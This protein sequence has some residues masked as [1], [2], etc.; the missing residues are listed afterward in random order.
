MTHAPKIAAQKKQPVSILRN[1]K[2]TLLNC[3]DVTKPEIVPKTMQN[4]RRL[5]NDFKKIH[6]LGL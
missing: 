1:E 5:T 4:Y 2:Y 3:F 6:K